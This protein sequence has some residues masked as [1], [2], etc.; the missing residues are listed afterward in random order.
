MVFFNPNLVA[1]ENKIRPYESCTPIILIGV[2][3]KFT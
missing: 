2:C 1:S 3:N